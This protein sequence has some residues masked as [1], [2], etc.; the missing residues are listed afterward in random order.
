MEPGAK[1]KDFVHHGGVGGPSKWW[2]KALLRQCKFSFIAPAG[3][4]FAAPS[5][6]VVAT[7]CNGRRMDCLRVQVAGGEA[8]VRL[9]RDLAPSPAGS[10]DRR[11][12]LSILAGSA[13]DLRARPAG[14]ACRKYLRRA[15]LWLL[16][17]VLH[18]R[19]A[20][21]RP[22]PLSDRCGLSLLY[23]VHQTAIILIAHQ[24]KEQGLPAGIEASIVIVGT[25]VSRAA[26][27]E[28]VRR[29]RVPRPLF[30]LRLGNGN[31]ASAGS[32]QMRP[33]QAES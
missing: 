28:I 18:R 10:A 16:S 7:A 25:V 6:I 17:V 31:Q 9:D 14:A 5:A 32:R 29:V 15:R 3:W 33:L 30:G 13:A 22:T 23:I 4:S 27:Y 11:R 1:S 19:G 26:T 21:F 8:R 20:R 24:L 12:D 2:N